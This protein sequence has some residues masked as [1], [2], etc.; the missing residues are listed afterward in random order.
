MS[1][2]V[3]ITLCSLTFLLADKYEDKLQSA[4]NR[5]VKTQINKIEEKANNTNSGNEKNIK[6]FV[7]SAHIKDFSDI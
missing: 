5:I 3:L 2:I 1:K 6:G 7:L 4:L